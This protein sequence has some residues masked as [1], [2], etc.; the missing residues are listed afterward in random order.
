ML[1]ALFPLAWF[2]NLI[3]KKDV[4][5]RSGKKDDEYL[6]QVGRKYPSSQPVLIPDYYP[7]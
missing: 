1:P 5:K 6:L 3:F 2:V 4:F 7:Y